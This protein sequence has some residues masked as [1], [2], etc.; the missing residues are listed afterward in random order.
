MIVERKN[1]I[2]KWKTQE[3]KEKWRKQQSPASFVLYP[4]GEGS[5]L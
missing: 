2:K 5:H 3:K 1:K 4:F